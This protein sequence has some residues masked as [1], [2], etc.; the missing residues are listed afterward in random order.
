MDTQ[1]LLVY[2]QALADVISFLIKLEETKA[3]TGKK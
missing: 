3:G 1:N 2:R